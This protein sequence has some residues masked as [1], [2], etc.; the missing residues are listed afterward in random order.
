MNLGSWCRVPSASSRRTAPSGNS[1]AVVGGCGSFTWNS[2][3]PG[4]S[5][6]GPGS[7]LVAPGPT[8]ALNDAG[9]APS[10][11]SAAPAARTPRVGL[12]G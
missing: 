8:R 12:G 11:C 10:A 5:G 6:A 2:F 7:S 3:S 9:P 4:T 1:V